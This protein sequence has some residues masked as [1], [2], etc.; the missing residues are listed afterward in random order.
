MVTMVT[1]CIPPSNSSNMIMVATWILWRSVRISI[2]F[3]LRGILPESFAAGHYLS[4]L[5]RPELWQID[6]SSC[7]AW[8]QA[9]TRAETG[10]GMV[11]EATAG[12]G[13]ESR[14]LSHHHAWHTS[15]SSCRS[16]C[17]A[18]RPSSSLGPGAGPPP[19]AAT[20][21]IHLPRL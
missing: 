7:C 14:L 15:R 21:P 4:H 13:Q 8:R 1:L 17:L 19:S 12:C 2:P 20:Q 9:S 5:P 11:G 16:C 3:F 6:R 18:Y 10:T